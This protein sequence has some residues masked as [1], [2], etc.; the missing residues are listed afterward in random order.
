MSNS[1]SECLVA[2]TIDAR[3]H[4]SV[5]TY[6]GLCGYHNHFTVWSVAVRSGVVVTRLSLIF[7][8]DEVS[9]F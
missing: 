8:G 3:R 9:I 7:Q 4:G 1:A 6:E 2:M 5:N